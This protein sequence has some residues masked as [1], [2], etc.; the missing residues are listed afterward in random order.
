MGKTISMIL[1]IRIA[2]LIGKEWT[3]VSEGKACWVLV[4]SASW[5]GVGY[6]TVIIFPKSIEL[7]S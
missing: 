6:I 7:Y 2:C 1:E 4:M 5:S 3:E